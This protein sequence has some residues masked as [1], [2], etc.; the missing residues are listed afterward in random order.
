MVEDHRDNLVVILAGYSG[1]MKV[2]VD[3]LT[4]N[5]TSNPNWRDEGSGVLVDEPLKYES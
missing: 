5:L 4:L 2:T 3:N 1:E